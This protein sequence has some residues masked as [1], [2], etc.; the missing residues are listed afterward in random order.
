MTDEP[1]LN[2]GKQA[3]AMLSIGELAER[4]GVPTHILRYWETRFPELRPLQRAGKRRYYRTE[5][6]ALVERIHH[7]LNNEGFTVEG[8]R[9]ALAG[10]GG[11]VA[12]ADA[13][14]RPGIAAN[15]LM[16]LRQR[17]VRAL[18]A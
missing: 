4:V 12:A 2:G 8:A 6:V 9:K 16:M 1:S 5:D 7:L 15:D 13:T 3:G 14:P 10:D 18:E 17:L 11:P